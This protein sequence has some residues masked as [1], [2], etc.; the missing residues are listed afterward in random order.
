MV[1][2]D[3]PSAMT[4][5]GD[6]MAGSEHPKRLEELIMELPPGAKNE[7]RDLIE[8][9][10]RR[11]EKGPRGKPRFDWTGVLEGLKDRYTSVDLQHKASEWRA[12]GG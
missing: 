8:F 4:Q 5:G 3:P 7:V 10:L 11:Q 6:I 1:G 2:E 9:L 12:G